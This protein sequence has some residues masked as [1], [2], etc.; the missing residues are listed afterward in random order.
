MPIYSY[1]GLDKTGKEIKQTVNAETE[2]QAKHKIK[3]SGIMLIN[4]KENKTKEGSS[5]AVSFGKKVKIQ[6]LA[7]M[8]RQLATLVKANS[9]R[10]STIT[11][12]NFKFF[13]FIILKIVLF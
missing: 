1:K 12:N 5:S 4:I 11:A 7:L 6:D 2:I 13:I 8:T 3:S 9:V 10:P